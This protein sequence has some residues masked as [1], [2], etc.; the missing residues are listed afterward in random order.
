MVGGYL[1]AGGRPVHLAAALLAAASSAALCAG[2]LAKKWRAL[3]VGSAAGALTGALSAIDLFLGPSFEN[4]FFV[5][6]ATLLFFEALGLA[7]GA[8]GEF[9]RVLHRSAH[10]IQVN[11]PH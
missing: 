11:K 5:G 3:F 6:L 7:L 9:I 2:F 4:E 10:D 1:H 8:I